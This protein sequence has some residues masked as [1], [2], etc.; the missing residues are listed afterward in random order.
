MKCL[1]SWAL[2]EHLKERFLKAVHLTE[3]NN[4]RFALELKALQAVSKTNLHC[5]TALH[6]MCNLYRVSALNVPT[7]SGRL[8]DTAFKNSKPSPGLRYEVVERRRETKNNREGKK[9]ACCL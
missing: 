7:G 3:G 4:Y 9:M 2:T 5:E 6:M 8:D 1:H